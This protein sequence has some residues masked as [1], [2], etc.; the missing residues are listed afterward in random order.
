MSQDSQA[1]SA[2]PTDTTTTQQSPAERIGSGIREI[3]WG[4][5]LRQV[6][7]TV[8]L[9]AGTILGAQ[10]LS[11]ALSDPNSDAS[12]A[13]RVVTSP[14]LDTCQRAGGC[15]QMIEADDTTIDTLNQCL[16]DA[17]GRPQGFTVETVRFNVLGRQADQYHY[18]YEMP[19]LL[20][21]RVVGEDGNIALNIRF[22]RV[23]TG[24]LDGAAQRAD[25]PPGQNVVDVDVDPYL[26]HSG[27]GEDSRV[28]GRHGERAL[29][30]WQVQALEDRVKPCM[31]RA[32]SPMG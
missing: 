14:L 5:P 16:T 29:R 20:L 32:L 2:S 4:T 8:A 12:A 10:A 30:D 23:S 24:E 7:T 3:T 28:R 21:S 25:T 27:Y 6:M 9:T 31:D 19:N 11:S 15:S 17:L 18:R 1:A 22:E 26:N 13:A